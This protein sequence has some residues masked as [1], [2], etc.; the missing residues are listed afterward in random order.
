MKL[1]LVKD[2]APLKDAARAEIDRQAGDV[3]SRFITVVPGQDMV[4]QEKRL[5][6]EQV[7]ANPEISPAA[8]PHIAAEAALNG[9]SLLDQ[10]AVVLTMAEQW[11]MLSA[12]IEARRHAAKAA[13]D[14]AT[15]P[16]LIDV[17]TKIDWPSIGR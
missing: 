5:E 6:A 12:L 8:V 4:Y 9:V 15:T 7:A 17:A 2:L 14:A 11:T 3:R 1:S 16:A 10:A 13:V